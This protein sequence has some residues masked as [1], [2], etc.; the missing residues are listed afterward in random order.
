MSIATLDT[1][2][3]TSPISQP[4]SLIIPLNHCLAC[5]FLHLSS[6]SP[7]TSA[8]FSNFSRR[9]S[10]PRSHLENAR[11]SHTHMNHSI[12]KTPINFLSLSFPKLNKR[13]RLCEMPFSI[14]FLSHSHS[15]SQT[16]PYPC[17]SPSQAI[18]PTSQSNYEEKTERQWCY[19]GTSPKRKS[20]HRCLTSAMG[21]HCC[22]IIKI[23]LHRKRQEK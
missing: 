16:I 2:I 22:R 13:N 20:T 23:S 1:F 6:Y 8:L 17:Q 21:V 3:S 15:H 4:A 7:S 5:S 19:H 14:L 12:P 10:H 11:I 9:L 18:P